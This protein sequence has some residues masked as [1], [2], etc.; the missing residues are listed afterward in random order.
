MMLRTVSAAKEMAL[1]E[2]S[3][4]CTTFSSRM[5]VMAPWFVKGKGG[6]V[7]R[8]KLVREGLGDRRERWKMRGEGRNRGNRRRGEKEGRK[9][10]TQ[11]GSEKR[12]GRGR[13]GDKHSFTENPPT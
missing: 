10:R 3:N 11:S 9:K 13:K 8:D 1:V 7:G 4:G 6:G 12:E 2:T 5:S